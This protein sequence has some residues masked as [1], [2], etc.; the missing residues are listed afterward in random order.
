MRVVVAGGTGF[1]GRPLVDRLAGEGHD[2]IVLSRGGAPPPPDVWA[3]PPRRLAV[4]WTGDASTTGWGHVVDGADAVINLAGESIAARRWT[5]AQKVQLERSR[6]DSTQAL[7]DAIRAAV[8]PPRLLISGSA[9][10]YYGARGD[11]VLT[12][13]ASP[14]DDFLA[15]LAV[16][17]ERTALQARSAITSV[18]LLRTGIALALDGGAL[19]KMLPLFRAGAG[20]P[21]GT[22]RQYMSWIHRA[23]WIALVQWTLERSDAGV[24]NAVA[25]HPV[26]NAEFTQALGTALRRPT[27]LR[28]PA[29]ALRLAMG[30]MADPLL[31]TGQRVV[32]ARALAEGFSFRYSTIA[33]AFDAIFA[34][35]A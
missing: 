19:A 24:F 12:E 31:L 1:L 10:G 26:T 4:R 6:L 16:V 2:V 7:V 22:G 28:V 32:P 18:V 14:G 8:R 9:T 29:M 5:R 3:S 20:G 21:L 15:R 17:W 27:L 13:S 30:E 25:P 23:D 34:P 11:E 35:G 33:A